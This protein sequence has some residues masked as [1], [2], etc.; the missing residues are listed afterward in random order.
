MAQ[1]AINIFVALTVGL[2]PGLFARFVIVRKPLKSSSAN[3]IAGISVLPVMLAY[4]AFTEVS[5]NKFTALAGA[6]VVTS[7][8]LA[9]A[10]MHR[11]YNDSLADRIRLKL[12]DPAI[13]EEEK[14]RMRAALEKLTK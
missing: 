1:L 14:L 12:N 3:W 8:L 2:L 11:G 9:R 5:E 7:F 6:I 4:R 13:D 10:I